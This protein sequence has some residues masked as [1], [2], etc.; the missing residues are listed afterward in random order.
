MVINSSFKI[1]HSTLKKPRDKKTVKGTI[2]GQLRQN[3]VFRKSY[4]VN[5]DSSSSCWHPINVSEPK[6]KAQR[7]D[8]SLFSIPQ[9]SLRLVPR[10]AYLGL[11]QV[12]PSALFPTSR[13]DIE[14]SSF[15]IKKAKR[16]EDR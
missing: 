10:L 7:W 5:S 16:Q 12:V 2:S 8:N 6:I 15:D 9:V 11:L 3:T 14:H 1:H 13:F 4:F